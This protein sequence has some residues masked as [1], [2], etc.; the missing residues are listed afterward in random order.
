[1]MRGGDL[2]TGIGGDREGGREGE[3]AITRSSD[4]LTAVSLDSG[5]WLLEFELP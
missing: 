1:M 3:G 5:I 2:G 4:L